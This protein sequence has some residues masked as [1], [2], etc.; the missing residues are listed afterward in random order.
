M[1]RSRGL[2]A[3]GLP[4]L[5]V[6]PMSRLRRRRLW[7][8]VVNAASVSYGPRRS[9]GVVRRAVAMRRPAV[10]LLSECRDFRLV[11]L[12]DLDVWQVM[13]YGPLGSEE[14]GTAILVR[15]DVAEGFNA[16]LVHISAEGEGIG[17]RYA[18]CVTLR[19]PHGGA[20]LGDVASVH[21]AP[22]YAPGRHH[23][24]MKQAAALPESH[25]IAGDF[26]AHRG[27]VRARFPRRRVR[28]VGVLGVVAG[29]AWAPGRA[30]ARRVGSDHA[31][32]MVPTVTL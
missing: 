13:Q 31:G 6:G 28:L 10:I 27:E 8:F 12:V 26:N 1:G 9:A 15:R 23:A 5:L 20:V 32:V 30:R 29:D 18:L 22:N 7:V 25:L 4:R 14:S 17:R 21:I 19:R 11:D 16:R 3:G 24:G 2:P